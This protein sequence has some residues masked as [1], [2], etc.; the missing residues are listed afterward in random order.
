MDRSLV[1]SI[2]ITI[3][4]YFLLQAGLFA[5]FAVPA[6]F[7]GKYGAGFLAASLS[8]HAFLMVLLLAFRADFVKEASGE[9]LTRVNLA[10]RIT[11]IRVSTLPTLLYLVIAAR[12]HHI[13]VPLLVLVAL[14]FLTD[15]ADG[16]VSR[17][18][19]EVTRAGKLLDSASDYCLIVV[20][21]IVFQYYE[22]IPAWFYALVLARL[23]IQAVFVAILAAVKRRLEP[24]STLMGKA[25][26]ASIMILYCLEILDLV[27]KGSVAG[28]L[29]VAEWIVAA[30]VAVSIG[31][32]A[33][34][35][36][37]ALRGGKASPG[38]PAATDGEA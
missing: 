2:V 34:N 22:L 8:F 11:L 26:V 13:R 25:A 33:V 14:V 15:F 27:A 24:R 28:P 38:K 3:V 30:I 19:N 5:A 17:R 31:D 6:G 4:A 37:Q 36:V 18:G 32:K 21:S 10:N 29:E 35:F 23:G 20:L 7:V 16:F 12:E 9:R 1:R